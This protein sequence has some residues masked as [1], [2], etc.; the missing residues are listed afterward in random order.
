MAVSGASSGR[1]QAERGKCDTDLM[2][3]TGG[4]VVVCT[5]LGKCVMGGGPEIHLFRGNVPEV[6]GAGGRLGGVGGRV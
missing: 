5:I 3:S 1:R 2:K 4:V 6:G